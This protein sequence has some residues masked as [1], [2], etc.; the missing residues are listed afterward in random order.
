MYSSSPW[1][2]VPP[3][4]LQ[5]LIE[6]GGIDESLIGANASAEEAAEGTEEQSQSGCNIVLSHCLQES[7]RSKGEYKKEIKVSCY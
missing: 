1:T 7:P 2:R 5:L 3:P 4:H 6:K